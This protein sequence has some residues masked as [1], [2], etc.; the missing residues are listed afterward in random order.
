LGSGTGVSPRGGARGGLARSPASWMVGNAGAGLR[1]LLAVWAEREMRRG[2]SA[3]HWQG[4]K[5]GAGRVGGH[6]RQEIRRQARV[7]TRRSTARAGGADLT[8]QVLGAER[9]ERGARGNGSA[10]GE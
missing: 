6:R 1:R 4:S 9:E 2:A 7:H 5:K 10:T 8:K 3:G